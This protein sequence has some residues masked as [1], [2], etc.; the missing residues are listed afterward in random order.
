M[1][2][3]YI[4]MEVFADLPSELRTL[5]YHIFVK[6]PSL[7]ETYTIL[8]TISDSS[9]IL[10]SLGPSITESLATYGLLPP[11][12]NIAAF[13]TPVLNAYLKHCTTAPSAPR[14]TKDLVAH[15]EICERDWVPLT[16][17]HLIPRFVHA[18]VLKRGWHPEEKLD[19]VAWLCR[20]CHS[21][22]HQIAGNE[23]LAKHYYTIE[24]LMEREEVRNWAKWAGK[25]RW[26][27]K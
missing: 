23:E 18:K 9:S 21:F 13:L 11:P 26:K 4:A 3:K 15:C 2:M 22:V 19:S 17:H 12:T 8:I 24:L 7:Q 27:S 5:T 1:I 14:L 6:S 10:N 20:Q 25:M 16:Y